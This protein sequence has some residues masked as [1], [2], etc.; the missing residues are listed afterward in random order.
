M[1]KSLS[2]LTASPNRL[3]YCAR[4]ANCHM[5]RSLCNVLGSATAASVSISPWA[6]FRA[7]MVRSVPRRRVGVAFG[8]FGKGLSNR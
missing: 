6:R 2:I 1:S 4:L 5:L 3:M 7:G 8:R